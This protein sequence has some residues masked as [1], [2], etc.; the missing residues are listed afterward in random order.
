MQ[1]A[2]VSEHA[3]PLAALGGV[4]SG[5]Q[6]VYVAQVSRELGALGHDV[7][8]FTRRDAVET[9]ET[10]ECG[11][12]VRVVQVEAGPQRPVPKEKLLPY[13][14]QFTRNTI[15]WMERNGETFDIVHANFFMSGLVAARIQQLLDI[16]FVITFHALGRVRRRH[17]GSQD[18]FPNSRFA[19]EEQCVDEAR[20]IIAE[21]PQDEDDLIELYDADPARI[22]MAPCGFSP[23]EMYPVPKEHARARLGIEGDRPVLLQLGRMVPRK[24]VEEVI[25][26]VG[27]LVRTTATEPLLLVVG[28]ETREPDPQATP[29]LGRLM[30][31]AR[32][33]GIEHLVRF[34]GQRNRDELRYYYSAADLFL[35]TPWY[36]PFGITPL[37]A[38]AC[39]TPVL[40]SRVG[41]IKFTV[42]D[43]VTGRL[44]EPRDP[45]AIGHALAGLLA[46]P[47]SLARMSE[48]ALERARS[49]TW[50]GVALQLDEIYMEALTG[51]KAVSPF[52]P[53]G[54][55]R[56]DHPLAAVG[57][58]V[59]PGVL[60]K[61][62]TIG[63][64]K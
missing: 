44:V 60:A 45:Q 18:G 63:R 53:T 13:M 46:R 52:A 41:G 10:V 36:E 54:E 27:H 62:S 57:F 16:P 50:A 61:D 29:E 5:G 42:M 32:E 11:P 34:E 47:E 49:F 9:G 40:G 64:G 26:G 55:L 3:S 51:R 43:G 21:C 1:I 39:G 4:D 30:E 56:R 15:S 38:M 20:L 35:S 59:S 14:E 23:E 17:Q 2:I 58:H 7:V 31:I 22:R 6:N 19:V 28:G 37:E 48:A 33:E 25:R 24:G 12:N 8:V